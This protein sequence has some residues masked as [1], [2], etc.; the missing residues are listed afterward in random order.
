MRC[1]QAV[2]MMSERLD[3]RLD[4]AE[5]ALLDEH[6]AACDACQAEWRKLQSLDALFAAAPV[7]PAPLRV[8]VQVMTRLARRDQ[9]R[10][11]L[12]GGTAL[13]LGT[14]ALALLALA[15]LLLGLLGA[16]G[17]LP[18][19]ISGGPETIVQILAF[20]ETASHALLVLAEKF[21]VPLA[22]TGLCSLTVAFTLNG[23]WL[24]AMR[25]LRAVH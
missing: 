12:V 25:R 5:I 3:G 11:A 16:T 18:A 10:R 21:I 23:L 22:F 2:Q 13:G 14:V 19:L 7:M 9:A 8:R 1:K 17:V 6:V 4:G 20:L 24:G 15:P